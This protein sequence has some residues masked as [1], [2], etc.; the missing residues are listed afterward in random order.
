MNTDLFCTAP[1]VTD[2]VTSE[3]MMV[4]KSFEWLCYENGPMHCIHCKACRTK[5]AGN[6]AFWIMDQL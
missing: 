3:M 1:K 2:N 5:V 6:T 4:F